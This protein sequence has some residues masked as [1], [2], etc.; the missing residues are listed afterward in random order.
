[1]AEVDEL[2]TLARELLSSGEVKAVIG[3]GAGARPDRTTPVIITSPVDVDQLVWNKYCDN[4]L[5]TYLTRSDVTRGLKVAIVAKGCDVKSIVGL[6]QESQITREQIVVIGMSCDGVA[7]AS[8]PAGLEQSVHERCKFCDVHTPKL[9]DKLIGKAVAAD[10]APG[11]DFYADVDKIES[12]K[13][14]ERWK[15][16]QEHFDRCIKC[17]ACRQVCPM[18][19][20]KRCVAEKNQPQWIATSAH[21]A[22]NFAWQAIRAM[23]L[24]GRCAGCGAC[25]RACPQDIPLMLLNKKMSREVETQFK[26]RAGYDPAAAPAVRAFDAAGD[27]NEMFR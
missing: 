12:M 27:S 5:A 23:H 8:V 10:A 20:C 4:N 13:P 3:Y 26:Y 18:C 19:Y 17:Y 24:A 2:R 7:P 16:W 15:F 11:K 22:G 9:Q 25:E 14:D 1:M 6:L 21:A